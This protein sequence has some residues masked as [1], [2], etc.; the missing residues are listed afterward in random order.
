MERSPL[1]RS[2]VLRYVLS[3]GIGAEEDANTTNN[4]KVAPTKPVFP[5][6]S[7]FIIF[8]PIIIF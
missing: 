6:K 5:F 4:E 3:N 8:Y 1:V 2:S 7:N